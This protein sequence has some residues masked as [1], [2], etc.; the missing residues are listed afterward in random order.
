[1]ESFFKPVEKSIN[2][3]GWDLISLYKG[4]ICLLEVDAIVTAGNEKLKGCWSKN[5]CID[6]AVFSAA[7]PNL[8]KACEGLAGCETGDAK[9]TPGYLLPAKYVIHTVGPYVVD[10]K[11]TTQKQKDQL[12]SCYLR[13]L[14]VAQANKL[15]S[16]AFCCISTGVFGF[17]KQEACEIA[18]QSVV[19]FLIEHDCFH[20]VIF[21]VFT[22][23]DLLLYEKNMISKG[24]KQ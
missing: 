12:R 4:D 17:P 6:A 23:E 16:V 7:G 15:K 19:D 9:I 10:S 5:H 13:S 18:L 21:C 22:E 2:C 3:R 1:M 24:L 8:F 14:R 11:I 20:Q